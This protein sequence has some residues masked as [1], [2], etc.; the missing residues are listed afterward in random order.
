[1]SS[2]LEKM[3]RGREQL[4]E[5]GGFSFTIR[6]PTD[7]QFAAIYSKGALKPE[8]LLPFVVGWRGV[9]D[10]DLFPGGDDVAS[11]FDAEDCAEWL[12]DRP[13]LLMPLLDAVVASYTSHIETFKAAEKN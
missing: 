13:D 7:L 10:K 5:L 9:K 2:R 1:M 4:V 6:R 11:E 8:S 3:R 12:S